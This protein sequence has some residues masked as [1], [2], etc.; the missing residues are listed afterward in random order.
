MH[1]IVGYAKTLTPNLFVHINRLMSLC[2]MQ[3][4]TSKLDLISI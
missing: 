3:A 4:V 1:T 2:F